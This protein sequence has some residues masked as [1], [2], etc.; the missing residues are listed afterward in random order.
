[1]AAIDLIHMTALAVFGGLLLWAA[2][3]DFTRFIIP[4][5]VSLALVALYPIHVLTAP[6]EVYWAFAVVMAVAV[7]LVG[8]MM[9]V[10]GAMGGGD[11]KLMAACTLWVG[12]VH[13][14]EF[15]IV[16]VATSALLALYAAVRLAMEEAATPEGAQAAGSGAATRQRP[17]FHKWVLNLRYVPLTK[18]TV[19]YGVA[20]AAGGMAFLVLT[21]LNP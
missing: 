16:M 4:N 12:P 20:I 19:P 8:F 2:W 7:F 18:L 9:F 21:V 1:M 17:A 10:L 6:V 13:L 3:S 5:A 14:V 15:L 11:V